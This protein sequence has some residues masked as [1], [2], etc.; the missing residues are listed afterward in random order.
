MSEKLIIDAEGAIFGRL[1]SYA[2]KQA[3]NGK[4]I[5][6]INSEKAIITGNRKD[7]LERYQRL[8][9]L[10]GTARKGPFYPKSSY[11]TLKRGIRGML[12]DHRKGIGKQAFQKIKCYDGIPEDLKGHKAIKLKMQEKNKYIELKNI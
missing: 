10:G 5:A 4:E 7:I 1:C 3:L 9:A 6:I 12:P 2:A 11:M 8:R